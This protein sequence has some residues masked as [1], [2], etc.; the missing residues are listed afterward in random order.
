VTTYPHLG[1]DPV[2]SDEAASDEIADELRAAVRRLGEVDDVLAGAGDQRWE[3]EA[4]EA[5][6]GSMDEELRPRVREALQSFATAS[7]AFDRWADALPSYRR[8]ADNLEAEAASAAQRVAQV[9]R[10]LEGLPTPGA[11]ADKA[12]RQQ[13]EG[14]LRQARS[15]LSS[16][17]S[18]LADVIRRAEAL[19]SEVVARAEEVSSAFD[20]AMNAA[21]DEPGLVGKLSD[22]LSEWK[23]W[24][25]EQFDRFMEEYAPLLQKLARI[26]GAAATILSIVA[27]V[28]G[29]VFP[30]A[31]AVA[32]ALATTAKIAGFVDIGIQGLRVLHGEPG[33]LQGFVLQAAGTLA[34][35]GAARAIG[36]VAV[37][38]QANLR[39]GMFVPQLA[40]VSVGSHGGAAVAVASLE[41]NPDFFHSLLYWG[42]TSYKDLEGSG[43]TLHEESR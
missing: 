3:G 28:V 30:P 27:F 18:E 41:V 7:R 39:N 25:A 1:F 15:S 4:A 16:A 21:P 14:E 9:S 38:A 36:P 37:N 20:T 24:A 19:R 33:S 23:D 29:F 13:F 40:G 5:F 43:E 32:S 26:V 10:H 35:I 17:Q 11:D 8:R 34:G 31:F 12:A 6:R 2:S 22:K 42:L